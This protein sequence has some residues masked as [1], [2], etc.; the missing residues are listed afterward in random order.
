MPTTFVTRKPVKAQPYALMP[1]RSRAAVGSAAET[2]IASNAISVMRMSRPR[3]VRR[4][5]G[6]KIDCG[7]VRSPARSSIVTSPG[8]NLDRTSCRGGWRQPRRLV[9][10]S[11]SWGATWNRSPTTPKSA[12]SKIGA[13]ASLLIATIVFEVCMPARCW[14]A[15]EMPTAM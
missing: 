2:A 13:S 7:P 8:C 1:C 15:P 14:M 9:I 6:A 4:T 5:S 11:V 12:S 3:L 10:S